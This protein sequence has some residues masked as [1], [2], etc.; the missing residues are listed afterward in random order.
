[1]EIIGLLG[2]G[3]IGTNVAELAIR[4][5]HDVVLSNSRGPATLRGLIERLGPR[6]RA[7]TPAGAA[8]DGDLV[9]LATPL[10]AVATLPVE[11]LRGKL[12]IDANNYSAER[13]GHIVE[14]DEEST[15]SSEW[16]QARLPASTVVKA[17]QQIHAP[18]LNSDSKPVGAPRRRALAVF[19]D[20]PRARARVAA[21]IDTWGFD[22]LDGG[23]LA[24]GWRLQRDTPGW[25]VYDT[26]P[27]LQSHL[28][29]ARRYRD[30]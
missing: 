6:A 27:E 14:L 1:M 5:G 28:A 26:V 3:S 18:Q 29:Q 11:E 22:P 13:D 24:E 4:H 10:T 12:V 8:R 17:F 25:D 15:T 2:A 7:A 30:M 16:L 21:L 9:V 20:D 23:Q 19:S